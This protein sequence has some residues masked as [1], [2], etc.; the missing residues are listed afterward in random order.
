MGWKFFN[1]TAQKKARKHSCSMSLFRPMQ[2]ATRSDESWVFRHLLH[3]N[4]DSTCP[5][6]RQCRRIRRVQA[7]RLQP[8]NRQSLRYQVRTS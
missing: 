8:Y 7:K 4:H 6:P 1:N 3:P 2:M 5:Y